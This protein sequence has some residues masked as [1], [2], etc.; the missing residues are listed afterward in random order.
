MTYVPFRTGA[1]LVGKA[2]IAVFVLAGTFLLV[3]QSVTGLIRGLV[4]DH[5]GAVVPGAEVSLTK[6][7]TG[8]VMTTST[9]TGSGLFV[10]P[11]V[12]AGTYTLQVRAQGFK[13]YEIRNLVLT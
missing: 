13:N 3:G 10:F 7:A 12:S 9:Q 4:V 11:S 6:V 8:T 2:I 5:S 1:I